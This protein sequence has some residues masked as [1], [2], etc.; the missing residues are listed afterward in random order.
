MRS[1]VFIS[2]LAVSLTAVGCWRGNPKAGGIPAAL[3]GG[4]SFAP[5]LRLNWP[6]P[7][8]ENSQI[9]SDG[10]GDQKHYTATFTDRSPR[11]VVTYFAYV[12]EYPAK[13]LAGTTPQEL[14]AAH[15]F[16][17][18]GDETSRKEIVHGPGKHP[19]LDITT[20]SG[21]RFGRKLVVMAGTRLYAVEIMS[22]SEEL[23]R[24][25]EAEAFFNSLAIDE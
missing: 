17:S 7:P 19:G 6:G 24:G 11:G 10:A 13:A 25:P 22:P 12:C 5:G 2:L 4:L 3:G 23:L 21:N 14:V 15:V 18:K 16:S 20:R 9:I 1:V 8:S